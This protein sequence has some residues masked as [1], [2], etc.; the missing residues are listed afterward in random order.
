MG[1]TSGKRSRDILTTSSVKASG[2]NEQ[3][4]TVSFQPTDDNNANKAEGPDEHGLPLGDWK[5]YLMDVC[6]QDLQNAA[7]SPPAGWAPNKELYGCD[8]PKS[9]LSEHSS[10]AL[11][12]NDDPQTVFLRRNDEDPLSIA[13]R[14]SQAQKV[15][16]NEWAAMDAS[17]KLVPTMEGRP[18]AIYSLSL[19]ER[20]DHPIA[21]SHWAL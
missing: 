10:V 13:L 9:I 8:P 21:S 12:M 14:E 5:D 15:P 20:C 4:D 11:L 19:R 3:D 16:T 7:N 1:P 17:G 18:Y 2:I 6:A